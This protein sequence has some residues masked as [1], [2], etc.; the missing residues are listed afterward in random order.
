MEFW[1]EEQVALVS[2]TMSGKIIST[3][4]NKLK[5]QKAPIQRVAD[6][7]AGRLVYLCF[8]RRPSITYLITHDVVSAISALIV[9]G[10]MELRQERSLGVLACIG[11]TA[12]EGI[13]V[14]GGIYL[15]SLVKLTRLFLIKQEHS[16]LAIPK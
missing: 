7:L 13:I 1:K 12:K 15:N 2:D 8:W 4:L 16:L 14:K 10:A 3:S 9:A 11:R 6:K 5:N